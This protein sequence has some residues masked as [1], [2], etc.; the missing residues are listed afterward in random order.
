MWL[1]W[2]IMN[3]DE[4][5]SFC[6]HF[7]QAR[8]MFLNWTALKDSISVSVSLWDRAYSVLLSL[9]AFLTGGELNQRRAEYRR[10]HRRTF[11]CTNHSQRRGGSGWWC[12]VSFSGGTWLQKNTILAG[13][14][15]SRLLYFK[16]VQYRRATVQLYYKCLLLHVSRNYRSPLSSS[17]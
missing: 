2:N 11:K 5:G 3:V 1:H 4:L 10:P 16:N 9:C 13:F 6:V 8:R 14:S 17:A 15:Y 7:K 12:Q